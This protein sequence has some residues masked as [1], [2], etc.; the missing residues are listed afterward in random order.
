MGSKAPPSK[1][2]RHE[3]RAEDDPSSESGSG[4]GRRL[5]AT[6]EVSE[7]SRSADLLR[8]IAETLNVE[9]GALYRA[10]ATR[11]AAPPAADPPASGAGTDGLGECL[12]LIGAYLRI[13][14]PAERRRYLDLIKAA[15]G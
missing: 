5:G 6:G 14:D 12:D 8:Q 3:D 1:F 13:R 10:A 7:G 2:L 11:G 4:A 9:P 15:A